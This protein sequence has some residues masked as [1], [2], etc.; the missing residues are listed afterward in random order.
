MSLLTVAGERSALIAPRLFDGES[1]HSQLA[2]VVSNGRIESLMPVAQLPRDMSQHVLP[3]GALVA[4]CV[5]IQVNGG[6]GLLFNQSPHHTTLAIMSAAHR[7]LGTVALLP[8]LITTD[9][10]TTYAAIDAVRYARAH[11]YSGIL[12]LHLEGPC[13]NPLRKGIHPEKWMRPLSDTL[14]SML[15]AGDL[16]QVIVTLAP[17]QAARSVVK[18]L[19]DAGVHV[20]IGHSAACYDEVV[21]ALALG[22]RGFTHLFN[23]MTPMTG[24]EP[25]VV[26]AALADKLSWCGVIN[27]T[28]HVHAA[29]LRIAL[30]AKPRGKL[31]LVSDAMSC[32]G[33]DQQ[34]FDLAQTRIYRTQGRLTTADGTLAGADLTLMQAVANTVALGVSVEEAL[35]MASLYPAQCLGIDDQYGRIAVGY[36]ADM[37]L[38]DEHTLRIIDPQPLTSLISR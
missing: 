21:C 2:V 26:G 15:T 28:F 25:G 9:E 23:A 17:E 14:L 1:W 36:C 11:R 20:F 32:A 24:R 38:I 35:R 8:T 5:D 3:Q 19:I 12:G 33:S 7:Q 10:Q 4:G 29:N 18:R 13:L 6:G 27:D 34:A 37:L 16:G 30:A 31:M 22:V